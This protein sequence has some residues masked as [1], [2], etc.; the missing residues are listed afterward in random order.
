[1]QVLDFTR[2]VALQKLRSFFETDQELATEAPIADGLKTRGSA[3]HFFGDVC[4]SGSNR[5]VE[6]GVQNAED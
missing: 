6:R 5:V 3:I 2:I 1:M 4:S